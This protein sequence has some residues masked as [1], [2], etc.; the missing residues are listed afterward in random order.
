MLCEGLIPPLRNLFHP[1]HFLIFQGLY[2][3]IQAKR[4]VCL[5][6]P[7]K[8]LFDREGL[9]WNQGK[10]ALGSYITFHCHSSKHVHVVATS[11]QSLQRPLNLTV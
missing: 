8:I 4:K 11:Q 2:L 5:L 7:P 1:N 9:Q 10:G 6:F 3:H